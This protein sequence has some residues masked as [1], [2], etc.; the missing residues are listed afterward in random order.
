MLTIALL[1]GCASPA[2]VPATP[3]T[4][5]PQTQVPPS[6]ASQSETVDDGQEAAHRTS[7]AP[8]ANGPTSERTPRA[9]EVNLTGGIGLNVMVC[10]LGEKPPCYGGAG[11]DFN[12]VPY[13]FRQ[14]GA[15]A[16]MADLTLT[17]STTDPAAQFMDVRVQSLIDCGVNCTRTQGEGIRHRSQSP[18]HLQGGFGIGDPAAI[19]VRVTVLASDQ[20]FQG[21]GIGA[22]TTTTTF[23]LKGTLTADLDGRFTP[24][25]WQG[26]IYADVGGGPLGSGAGTGWS[27]STAIATTPYQHATGLVT[28]KW[29][30]TNPTM[31]KLTAWFAP[32]GREAQ[33]Q[34]AWQTVTGP[35]PLEADLELTAHGLEDQLCVKVSTTDGLRAATPQD[36]TIQGVLN[37][38][39]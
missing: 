4:T 20:E 22:T 7:R 10:A 2:A 3:S 21:T 18:L 29:T 24:V 34:L 38:K 27:D 8:N 16:W 39:P 1:A 19:G 15:R 9:F 35:S 36:F 33:T 37:T 28:L 26:Q 14:P 13:N 32:C 12:M 31:A 25:L 11:M 23:T 5:A 17:W 6:G 30:A